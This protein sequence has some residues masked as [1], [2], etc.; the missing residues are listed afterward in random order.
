MRPPVRAFLAAILALAAQSAADTTVHEIARIQGQSETVLRGTALVVGLGKS[1][2]SGKE[3]ALARPLRQVY[4]NNGNPVMIEDVAKATSVA[5]VSV[6]CR[7]PEGGGRTGDRFDVSVQTTLSAKSLAGGTLYLAALQGP[8]PD[9]PVFA[10]AEGELIIDDD[11]YPTRARVRGG[12]R[13]IRD[14]VTGDVRD[15]FTLILRPPYAGWAA[16]SEVAGTITQSIYGKT[17]KGLAGLPQVATVIDDRTIRIDIPPVERANTA[18]FVGDVLSTPINISLLKLPAQVIYNQAAGRIVVTGDVEISPVAIT[19]QDLTI[20]TT[21]PPPTPTPDNPAFETAT[22]VGVA[23][24]AKDSDRARLQDLL[25][26]FNQ[27]KVPVS[28]QIGILE[29]LEKT[30]KLHA[31]VVRE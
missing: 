7:I 15:S 17:G 30:G 11:R 26:A 6:M 27:L 18:A 22:W 3:L 10:I 2:D 20:T 9:D 29:M 31:R 4:A 12:A 1:G 25:N 21:T 23:P 8:Y 28:D 19:S 5:L 16:A 14:I 24:G 13:L